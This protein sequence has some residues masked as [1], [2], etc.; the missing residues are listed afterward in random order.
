MKTNPKNQVRKIN[1]KTF[2]DPKRLKHTREFKDKEIKEWK[3]ED[4]LYY[5]VV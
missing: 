3:K 2:I 1:K 5:F 4:E